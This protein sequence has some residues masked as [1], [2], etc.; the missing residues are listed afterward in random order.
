MKPHFIV[1]V[2]LI[3]GG[4]ENLEVLANC[5]LFKFENRVKSDYSNAGGTEVWSDDCEG[6][7]N[8]G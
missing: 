4:A 2:E 1:P 6:E 5:D 8:A 3:A 7:D